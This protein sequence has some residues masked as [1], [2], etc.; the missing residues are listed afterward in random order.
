MT[1][2]LLRSARPDR[3][4]LPEAPGPITELLEAP[5]LNESIS[6]AFALLVLGPGI[7]SMIKYAFTAIVLSFVP[8]LQVG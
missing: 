6:I 1:L 3:D 8:K 4:S 7:P 5:K 2:I